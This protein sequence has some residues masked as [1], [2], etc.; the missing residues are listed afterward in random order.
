VVVQPVSGAIASIGVDSE[1]IVDYTGVSFNGTDELTLRVCDLLAA[2][3][4]AVIL[5]EVGEP[6]SPPVTVYNAI[7]PNGDGKHDFLEIENIEFYP[8]NK[9][10]LFNRWGDVVYESD[11]YNNSDV[12]FKGQGKSSGELSAGTYY[13]SVDLNDGT[14]VLTG[15]VMLNK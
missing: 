2:C 11:G 10:T 12:A 14:E 5:I 6:G 13:Y 7:S 1:L 4:N 15:F 8:E 3:G 9:V